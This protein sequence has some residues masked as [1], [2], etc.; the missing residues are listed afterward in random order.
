M[1][2]LAYIYKTI[3]QG[4]WYIVTIDSEEYLGQ[5]VLGGLIRIY[6]VS[7]PENFWDSP[8][9][10]WTLQ[11]EFTGKVMRREKPGSCNLVETQ[12]EAPDNYDPTPPTEIYVSIA[13][14]WGDPEMHSYICGT[15][16]TLQGI[17]EISENQEYL[18]GGKYKCD[19][20]KSWV[21]S[22]IMIPLNP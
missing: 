15:S 6:R 8:V 12:E 18:R 14:R 17:R 16:Y 22:D 20:Y 11:R 3:L 5:E 21:G 19:I 7:L 4:R 2:N 10:P 1:E 9:L 13:R